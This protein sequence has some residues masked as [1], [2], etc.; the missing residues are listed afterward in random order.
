MRVERAVYLALTTGMV[1]S[2]SLLSIGILLDLIG[3]KIY[4]NF[5]LAGT[6]ILVLT[7]MARVVVAII[8]F[9]SSREFYNV[10]VASVVLLFMIL[11][12]LMG[13][14]LRVVPS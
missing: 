12:I 6:F 7:P 11:G 13:L 3:M 8:A 4:S 5:L 9:T 1:I 14:I 2:F 10:A